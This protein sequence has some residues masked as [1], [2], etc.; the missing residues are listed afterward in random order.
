M[1]RGIFAD[2]EF[3]ITLSPDV[4]AALQLDPE[5]MKR[6]FINLVDNAIDA[7]NKKGKIFIHTFFDKDEQ[8]VKIEVSDTGPGIH[9]EDKEKLFLPHFST[10]KKG[11]GLGLAIVSQIVKEHNGVIQVQNNRPSGAKFILQLPA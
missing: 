4:P 11:T 2:V 8:Q 5:Q 10:K 7:M 1:F 6:V 3:E 9:I